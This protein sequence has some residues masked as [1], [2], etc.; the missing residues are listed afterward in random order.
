MLLS[1]SVELQSD[2]NRVAILK[3][4]NDLAKASISLFGGH[5][6]SF[7][8]KHDDRE[9][10]WLSES[11][12]LDGSKAIRGGIPICWPWF[13]DHPDQDLPAHGYVR[14]Q[15]WQVVGCI[16]SDEGTVIQIKPET[17]VA[18]GL[19]GDA[20][21]LMSV[22]IGT[23]LKIELL[24]TNIGPTD[25]CFGAALHSYFDIQRIDQSRLNGL[26]GDYLDKTEGY[27][28]KTTPEQYVFQGETDRV[29]LNPVTQ[30]EIVAANFSTGVK[31]GGHDSVVVW[32]PWSEKSKAMPDMADDGYQSMLCVESAIT[33]GQSL[34]AGEAHALTQIIS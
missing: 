11:A 23:E 13:G 28:R 27:A 5:I 33:Q 2:V 24:T 26:S 31:S 17:S 12:V 3:V 1:Q 16:E 15:Q 4:E 10:L 8:P 9:R 7:V 32:N 25:F 34:A 21:L 6:L 29:H 14:T 18:A 22:S 30:V 20:D 19:I